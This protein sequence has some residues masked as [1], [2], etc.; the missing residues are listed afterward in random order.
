MS[1][2][3]TEK[4]STHF[5]AAQKNTFSTNKT[6]SESKTHSSLYC[7]LKM[8]PIPQTIVIFQH[9]TCNNEQPQIKSFE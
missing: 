4:I 1:N 8:T 5:P 2:V 6:L 3:R 9:F 7:K